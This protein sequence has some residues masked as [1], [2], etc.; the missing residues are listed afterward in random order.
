MDTIISLSD[1]LVEFDKICN[2][3]FPSDT[4]D[5]PIY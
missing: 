1:I 4:S 3:W 5:D 2:Y